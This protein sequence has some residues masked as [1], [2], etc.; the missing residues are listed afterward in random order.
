MRERLGR[1]LHCVVSSALSVTFRASRTRRIG[2]RPVLTHRLGYISATF[3]RKFVKFSRKSNKFSRKSR[4]PLWHKIFYFF[5]TFALTKPKS[6]PNDA[7][8]AHAPLQS[9]LHAQAGLHF[10]PFSRTGWVTSRRHFRGNL[11][12]FNKNS[13]GFSRKSAEP[14]WLTAFQ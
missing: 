11:S 4:E 3:S 8:D 10:G 9:A 1:R 2:L 13:V 12:N 7:V 5:G 14:L 6:E